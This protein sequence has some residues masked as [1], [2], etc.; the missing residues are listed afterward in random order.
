MLALPLIQSPVAVSFM[1]G[2]LNQHNLVCP[3]SQIL[4]FL[5]LIKHP[6]DSAKSC[7]Q[8]R[9]KTGY[10]QAFRSRLVAE[11]SQGANNKSALA[12]AFAYEQYLQK[13]WQYDFVPSGYKVANVR[14]VSY[15]HHATKQTRFSVKLAF[16]RK[17]MPMINVPSTVM[18]LLE[19]S[20]WNH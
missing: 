4:Y 2:R 14:A 1:A 6:L 12:T 10:T 9:F 15:E 3:V 20:K 17:S 16:S 11:R 19:T 8:G 5:V 13:Y 18:K 7:S